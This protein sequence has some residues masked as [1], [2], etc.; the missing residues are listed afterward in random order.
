MGLA[1]H[2]NPRQLAHAREGQKSVASR[3]NG[4]FVLRLPGIDRR[5]DADPV[6]QRRGGVEAQVLPVA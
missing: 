2:A 3:P 5:D 6:L 1:S 4:P